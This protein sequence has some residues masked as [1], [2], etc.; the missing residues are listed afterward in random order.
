MVQCCF[1]SIRFRSA[2]TSLKHRIRAAT[3][4]ATLINLNYRFDK[5]KLF[6]IFM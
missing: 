2:A 1:L 5:M 3:P 6:N 4:R